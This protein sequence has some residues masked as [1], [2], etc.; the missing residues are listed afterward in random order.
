[1][2]NTIEVLR[3][4]DNNDSRDLYITGYTDPKNIA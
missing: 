4:I 3:K 2:K 1:L